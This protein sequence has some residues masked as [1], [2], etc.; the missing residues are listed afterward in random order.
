MEKRSKK[1]LSEEKERKVEET[2]LENYGKYYRLAYSYCRSEADAQDIVQEGAYLAIRNSDSLKSLEYAD[3]WLY[4][5]MINE[6]L[7]FLRKNKRETVEWD[8]AVGNGQDGEEMQ[9]EHIRRQELKTALDALEPLDRTIIILRFFEDL[10]LEQIAEVTE[11]NL[12]TVKSRLY[13]ALK[14]LRLLLGEAAG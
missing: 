4:R 13:R 7:G 3:T 9:E 8:E 1:K 10:K 14:K 12:N 6:A 2:L 5:I 11:E